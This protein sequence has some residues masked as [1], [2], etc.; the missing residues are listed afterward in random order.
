MSER[1]IYEIAQMITDRNNIESDMAN[2]MEMVKGLFRD[3]YVK[4]LNDA[5]SKCREANAKS[6][7][8][9]VRLLQALKPFIPEENHKNM[10]MAAE[11]L[12]MMETL[13]GIRDEANIISA[14]E[15]GSRAKDRKNEN[16]RRFIPAAAAGTEYSAE[17]D[18]ADNKDEAIHADG[19]Y[20]MDQNCMIERTGGIPFNIMSIAIASLI[21]KT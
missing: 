18:I 20:E 10:E 4:R 9:E 5:F 1:K 11:M 16:G 19:I 8:K 14:Q 21:M 17:E 3:K 15:S 13:K 12:L 7:S 2:A 6:P